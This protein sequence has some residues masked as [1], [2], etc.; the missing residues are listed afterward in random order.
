ME[1]LIILHE[2]HASGRSA[3]MNDISG[4]LKTI[5]YKYE[6]YCSFSKQLTNIYTDKQKGFMLSTDGTDLYIV[7]V[8]DGYRINSSG[9]NTVRGSFSAVIRETPVNK[10]ILKKFSDKKFSGEVVDKNTIKLVFEKE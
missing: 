2:K 9:K 5:G 1:G 4:K 10:E 3:N 8:N 7:F 6:L